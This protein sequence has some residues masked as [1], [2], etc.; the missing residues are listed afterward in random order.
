MEGYVYLIKEFHSNTYKIGKAV[1]VENRL[2]I[3]NVKLPFKWELIHTIKCKD[4]HR[5]E[6]KAHNIFSTKRVNGEW[7]DLSDG[8]VEEIKSD[9]F[10]KVINSNKKTKKRFDYT[11]IYLKPTQI[12]GVIKDKSVDE[13]KEKVNH[14]FGELN[15]RLKEYDKNFN[16]MVK[17]Q[18]SIH[19][20]LMMEINKTLNMFRSDKKRK[21][22][23]F[24]LL[25]KRIKKSG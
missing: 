12:P 5:A 10:K 11:E 22:N 16:K 17:D 4:Y 13:H 15:E 7:F 9:S 24:T 20:D 6:T 19:D 1:N 18:E 3:F 23:L 8:D 14:H 25:Y 21:E 2:K